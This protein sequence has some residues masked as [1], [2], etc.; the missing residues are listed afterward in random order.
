MKLLGGP[1]AMAAAGPG[2]D[3]DRVFNDA[4]T[5]ATKS[6]GD[7]PPDGRASASTQFYDRAARAAFSPQ[8]QVN[9]RMA[10]ASFAEAGG[11]PAAAVKLYQEIL[12][13]RADA[14]GLGARREGGQAR[15]GRRTRRRRRS[16]P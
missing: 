15:P 10:R 4:L 2:A 11:D 5:F 1:D 3:R 14:G 9:Y 13:D 8:Q 16:T 6:A 7:R 12:A